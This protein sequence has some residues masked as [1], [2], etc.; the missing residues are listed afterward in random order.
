MVDQWVVERKIPGTLAYAARQF[1]ND[2]ITLEEVYKKLELYMVLEAMQN[3]N[4]NITV[5]SGDLDC[6]RNR[7]TRLLNRAS[8]P[9]RQLKV[10]V[11]TA[12]RRIGCNSN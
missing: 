11:Q 10:E 2:G 3:H 1:Y 7:C 4:F 5:A 12:K 8:I 9:P 6:N